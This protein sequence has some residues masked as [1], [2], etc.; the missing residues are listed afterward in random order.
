MSPKTEALVKEAMQLPYA[1]RA[2]LVDELIATLDPEADNDIEELWAIEVEKRA[3]ELALG[4][5]KPVIWEEVKNEAL[6]R[7]NGEK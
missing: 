3:I 6:K 4:T 7:V 5:V 1:E 2:H